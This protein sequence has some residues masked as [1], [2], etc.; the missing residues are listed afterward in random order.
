MRIMIHN[1]EVI[2]TVKAFRNYN[3]R[4]SEI[5]SENYREVTDR[6]LEKPLFCG[7]FIAKIYVGNQV[8]GI[9]EFN[10]NHWRNWREL[11]SFSPKIKKLG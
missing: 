7:S 11:D 8:M 1:D 3:Q 9:Y 5:L 4:S 2:R 10:C 6:Q